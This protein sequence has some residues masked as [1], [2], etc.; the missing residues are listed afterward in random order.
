MS[1]RKLL[2]VTGIAKC[3]FFGVD[4]SDDL[5]AGVSALPPSSG[6]TISLWLPVLY[7]FNPLISEARLSL[8]L[9]RF[10]VKG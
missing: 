7:V 9:C 8:A 2:P 10:L 3:L 5:K 4:L 1:T 6:F